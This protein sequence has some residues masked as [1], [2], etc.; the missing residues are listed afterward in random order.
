M[1][2]LTPPV[3]ATNPLVRICFLIRVLTFPFFAAVLFAALY[4]ADLSTMLLIGIFANT[5]FWPHVAFFLAKRSKTPKAAEHRN[6]MLD[7]VIIGAWLPVIQ[8][9]VLPSVVI[10]FSLMGGMMSVGGPLLALGGAAGVVLG[11]VLSGLVVGFHVQQVSISA[12]GLVSIAAL[13]GFMVL[14][15][16]LSYAQSKRVVIGIRK[17]RLQHAEI[18]E[19]S[20]LLE[21]KSQELSEAKEIAEASSR[22]KSQFLAN[23]SHELRTPLNG[24][25]GYSEMLAEEAQDQ[26]HQNYVQ[27]LERIRYSGKHLLS[28]INQVLDLSKV[29][30][31][32]MDLYLESFELQSF[33]N[34]VVDNLKPIVATNKNQLLLKICQPGIVMHADQT[35]LRQVLLN[36]LSNASKFTSQGTI[37]L[38]VGLDASKNEVIMAVS[39]TGI[40]MTLE[41]L[42]RLFQPFT[43]GDSST[44]KQYGGTGLGLTISKHFVEMMGGGISVSSQHERGSTFTVRLPLEIPTDT[45]DL[46]AQSS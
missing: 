17:S 41:Q 2:N 30:A 18:L 33:L 24:I 1:S 8:F 43:Q 39:D 31:G 3:P 6:L 32:K 9:S 10:S 21:Q 4:P 19:K 13:G 37:T 44:T 22:T 14:F 46:S 34:S 20:I 36:L 12:L 28:L 26:G 23:M 29:E 15:S 25:I 16:Y 11:V 27:D 45:K 42:A 40:G 5:F 7:A 35:K 38:E